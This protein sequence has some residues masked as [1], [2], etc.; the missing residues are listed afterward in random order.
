PLG[1]LPSRGEEPGHAV[2]NVRIPPHLWGRCRG[3]TEGA[4]YAPEPEGSPS[5]TPPPSL[6]DFFGCSS[7]TI[8]PMTIRAAPSK[9]L[10]FSASRCKATERARQPPPARWATS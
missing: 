2:R 10:H 5:Y 6:I 4:P 9:A 1:H 7:L 3:A 8:T